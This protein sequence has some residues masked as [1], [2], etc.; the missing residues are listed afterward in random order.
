MPA[1]FANLS[2]QRRRLARAVTAVVAVA[3]VV[4][5]VAGAVAALGS[6]DDRTAAAAAADQPGPV[7]LVPGYGA[8]SANLEALAVRL[9][10]DGHQAQ[11]VP[12]PDQNTGD[13][14]QQVDAVEQAVAGALRGGAPSVDVVGYSAGGVVA[15]LWA[16]EHDGANRARRIVT[17]GAPFHGTTLAS[18]GASLLPGLCPT[19]CQ[20]LEPDSDLLRSLGPGGSA[21]T[22]HPAW[23]S[24]W[25][26][27]DA[28]VTPPDSARL[29]GALNL[30]VQSVCATA[31]VSHGD[32]PRSPLVQ[33]MVLTELA[34]GGPVPL[35][36]ADCSRLAA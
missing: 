18:T 36:A 5:I 12:G 2:P 31:V 8:P 21:A 15:L 4:G 30:S 33:S 26:A 13:L 19:A 6:D 20:Q 27:N 16:K 11:V 35:A 24:I 17:L 22:D 34:A 14:R 32:L 25:T 29:T 3:V 28:T 23:L 1:P 7:V 9:R 10:A